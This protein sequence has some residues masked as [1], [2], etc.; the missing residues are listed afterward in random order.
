MK[1]DTTD[2]PRR[3]ITVISGVESKLQAAT[4]HLS[5]YTR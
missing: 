2:K 1:Q 4:S 3:M 5:L